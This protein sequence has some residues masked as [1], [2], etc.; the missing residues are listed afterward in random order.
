[1]L[2]EVK[3]SRK[4]L[5]LEVMVKKLD[6][7][8]FLNEA[9][10]WE[11]QE[12]AES[13]FSDA[14]GRTVRFDREDVS[15]L[16][17]VETYLREQISA[18]HFKRMLDVEFLNSRLEQMTFRL[19]QFNE[20]EPA[21]GAALPALRATRTTAATT[22]VQILDTLL[23]QFACFVSDTM[24]G[25][26]PMGVFRCEGLCHT[27]AV[28][29]CKTYYDRFQSLEAA[30]KLEV[31]ADSSLN[32]IFERCSDYFMAGPGAKFCSDSCRFTTFALRKKMQTPDYQAAKQRRYRE[33]K[34]LEKS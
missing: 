14:G 11:T 9:A 26:A 23:F 15:E 28:A 20:I 8:R 13:F 7:V 16:S 30:W 1:L 19:S 18:L 21:S 5:K 33:R 34:K 3:L 10:T 31:V 22:L 17:A 12:Q 24:S 25:A 2:C 29:D 27:D 6:W 32:G 4:Q